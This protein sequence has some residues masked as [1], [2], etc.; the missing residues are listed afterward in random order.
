[1]VLVLQLFGVTPE[2]YQEMHKLQYGRTLN[3]ILNYLDYAKSHTN[4]PYTSG[5]FIET[6]INRH[7]REDWIKF[8]EEKLDEISVWKPHSWL[9]LKYRTIDKNNQISCNRP[10]STVY[11][12]ANGDVALS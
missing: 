9:D 6:D 7:E 3:N 8:W 4:K 5:L 11:V 10:F 2:T 1:M 12:H